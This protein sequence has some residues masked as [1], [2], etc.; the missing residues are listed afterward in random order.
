MF[1]NSK[2][3]LSVQIDLYDSQCRG[4]FGLGER[5]S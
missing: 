3:T 4:K 2:V 5:H 1:I